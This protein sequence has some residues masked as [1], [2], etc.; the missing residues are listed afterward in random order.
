MLAD[1]NGSN[2]TTPGKASQLVIET[3]EEI[4]EVED[5]SFVKTK[6]TSSSQQSKP[7][8]LGQSSSQI[9]A[10]QLVSPRTSVT[11]ESAAGPAAKSK[12]GKKQD[13]KENQREEARKIEEEKR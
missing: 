4:G 11:G 2:K 1:R 10:N 5:D 8:G 13:N 9:A 6:G 12:L 3:E 7:G